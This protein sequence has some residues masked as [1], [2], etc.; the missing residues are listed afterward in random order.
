MIVIGGQE[1]HCVPRTNPTQGP[2]AANYKD[3][4][5]KLFATTATFVLLSTG[6]SLAA[7]D[8][9][10]LIDSLQSQG[11][12]RIEV[13]NGLSQV[14]IEAI[15][16]TEKVEV[17]YDK[18]TGAV[19]KSETETVQ[20]GDD[21]A[22]GVSIETRD[23]DFLDDDSSDESMDDVNDDANDDAG[24][25]SSDDG[26][27]DSGDDDGGDSGDDNG[28]DD[29]GGDDSGG[30]DNGGDDSGGDDSGG[31]DSGGDEGDDD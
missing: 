18:E 30:D 26:S 13:K 8:T 29:N 4:T 11:Y 10:A 3:K 22:A 15:R 1:R 17:V 14:K 28:G 25:D 9:N 16:G 21:V 20:P 12:T 23:E 31:D 24:D 2:R 19:L 5:M 27:N 6:L 7:V